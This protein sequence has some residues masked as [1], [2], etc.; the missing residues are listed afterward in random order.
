MDIR[1]RKN[2]LDK[3]IDDVGECFM[4]LSFEGEVVK[5][6]CK[7]EVCWKCDGTGSYVNPNIDRHGLTRSDL[8]RD[9]DFAREYFDGSYDQIC[10]VC[11][12]DNVIVRPVI[13]RS[14]SEEKV[15]FWVNLKR[16]I[17]RDREFESLQ[18]Q[19]RHANRRKA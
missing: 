15:H 11:D 16:Q 13:D 18:Y 2:H 5:L 19:E 10:D 6:P 17:R 14:L 7:R 9:P 3:Y 1:D 12:G 4:T 8:N